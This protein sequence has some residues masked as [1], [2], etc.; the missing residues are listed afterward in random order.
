MTISIWRYSHLT[1]VISSTLFIV[2]ASITGIILAFE[3]ISDKL[4]PYD[5]VDINTV[6]IQETIAVLQKN[7]DEVITLDVDENGFVAAN[8]VLKNGKSDTFYINP[9]TGEKVGEILQKNQFLNL[10]Q[11]YIV[12]YF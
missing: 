12:H 9:K 7:Y 5:V 6:S 11:I 3:P 8:V 4:S 2:L 10:Q 1:L